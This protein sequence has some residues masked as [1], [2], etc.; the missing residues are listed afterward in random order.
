MRRL[1]T[2]P[3][4]QTGSERLAAPVVTAA[5]IRATETTPDI[6][7]NTSA[8]MAPG[9]STD[10]GP[11]DALAVALLT[12]M[13]TA[14]MLTAVVTSIVNMICRPIPVRAGDEIMAFVPTDPYLLTNTRRFARELGVSLTTLD[15]LATYLSDVE[16]ARRQLGRYVADC[17]L[18][19][20]DR[21]A[22]LHQLMLQ[23]T[24]RTAARSAAEALNV[25]TVDS[26]IAVPE[27]HALSFSVLM[28]LL[29]AAAAGE[30][31]CVD[32][33]GRAFLPVLPQRRRAG[34]QFVGIGGTLT[35]R[36]VTLRVHVRD[37]S[38]GGAGLEGVTS[39]VTPNVSAILE[40][41]TGRR[42]SASVAWVKNDRAGLRF[43][44]DLAPNDP[45]I[46]G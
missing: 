8:Q 39:D 6:A 44:R 5:A 34:R 23:A 35:T 45:L 20:L 14:A 29:A 27:L 7:P 16:T 13:Q 18:I 31:P 37:I 24:W 46:Y 22:A 17:E 12:D 2:L 21:A 43:T 25:L 4:K 33:T 41:A 19:G 30:S 32:A 9:F 26:T 42:L 3:S 11:N 36:G 28:R 40:L 15:G 1:L 38:C 10:S